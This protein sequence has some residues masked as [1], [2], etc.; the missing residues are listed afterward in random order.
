LEQIRNA[1]VI[2]VRSLELHNFLDEYGA[3]LSARVIISGNSDHEFHE[4]LILPPSVKLLLLQ[5]S[6][7]SDGSRIQTLPIG[8]ENFR[9]GVNGNPKFLN[10]N[11]F[12]VANNEILFGPFGLT[13]SARA[14]V[15]SEISS[16]EGPW[17]LLEGYIQPH[18]FDKLT[19]RY[20]YVAAVRGNGRDT[21][22]LWEALYRGRYP[23]MQQ[24]GWSTSLRAL[25]LPIIE[26]SEWNEAELLQ[27]VDQP[28]VQFNPN[29]LPAL[30]MKYWV[31]KIRKAVT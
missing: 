3:S 19:A 5:N 9:W 30:W 24:D 29:D 14:L 13:H 1:R 10:F 6:F 2:F 11:R 31:E 21:H 16:H 20:R 15:I 26:V 17:N 7:V 27:V 23:I 18:E 25:G 4:E 28:R 22:R 12:G 8:I